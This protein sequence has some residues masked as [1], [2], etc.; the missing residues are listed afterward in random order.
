M[1]ILVKYTQ[2]N[3]I[4]TWAIIPWLILPLVTL[5]RVT[6]SGY[7]FLPRLYST[8]VTLKISWV[9]IPCSNLPPPTSQRVALPEVIISTQ[10]QITLGNLIPTLSNYRF[11]QGNSSNGN[12]TWVIVWV[13]LLWVTLTWVN[14]PWLPLPLVTLRSF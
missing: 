9:I 11:T 13:L 8:W 6:L 2:E 10:V 7:S 1:C 4:L 3:H 14:I 12:L 5:P